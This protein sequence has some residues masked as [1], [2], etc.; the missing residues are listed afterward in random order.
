MEFRLPELGENVASATILRVLAEAGSM[1]SEGEAL[2]ELESDKATLE[3]PSPVSG[4]VE[5]VLVQEGEPVRVG[6]PLLVIDESAADASG[7]AEGRPPGRSASQPAG[8]AEPMSK[9][10]GRADRSAPGSPASRPP[11]RPPVLLPTAVPVSPT[12]AAIQLPA[13]PELSPPVP[14]APEVEDRRPGAAHG[15][16]GSGELPPV[17]AGPATRRLAR[18]LG[19]DLH[20]VHGSGRGGR[21]TVDDVKGFVRA[22]GGRVIPEPPGAEWQ[23]VAGADPRLA[24]RAPSADLSAP[25]LPDFAQWGEIERRPITGIRRATAEQMSLAWRLCPQV[26]QY[27]QADITELEAGRKRYLESLPPGAPKVTATV[28]AI[29]AVVAALRAY[30]QFNA[31]FD[32]AAGEWVFKRYFH[33][34]VAV[35]TEHGLLVPV[36]RD[37]DQKNGLELAAEL[38]ELA[39]RARGRKLRPEEMRGGTFTITNLGSIGGTAF[40][41]IVNYPELAILGLARSSWQQVIRDGQ[42]EI[43]L[44][45]PLCLSYDHR[46]IDGADGARFI[47]HVAR[48]LA[49]PVRLLVES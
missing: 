4:R 10:T 23:S 43:R 34:G 25:P 40:S 42:P 8:E 37:A 14:E 13:E 26:T 24:R 19:V 20:R 29:K 16:P 47:T 45:L 28:L 38:A 30:P 11:D 5:K 18:E 48:A 33:I 1:V 12:R 44:M 46:V 9:S 21:V 36:I 35:D 2:L 6:D 7:R 41:P 32:A 3:L 49:D 15:A 31:S 17:P 39:E 27:D 22:N